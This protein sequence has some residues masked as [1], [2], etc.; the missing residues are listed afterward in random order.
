MLEDL[1]IFKDITNIK[2][3]E[4]LKFAGFGCF[5]CSTMPTYT[6]DENGALLKVA[7]SG[8]A[9][10]CFASVAFYADEVFKADGEVYM[11]AT[12]D[13]PKERTTIVGFDKRSIVLPIRGKDIG[14]IISTTVSTD[15]G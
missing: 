7:Y 8:D 13:N 14:A 10:S 6:T 12:Y 2:D 1:K 9:T 5:S 15:N 3:G 11:Y 4:P